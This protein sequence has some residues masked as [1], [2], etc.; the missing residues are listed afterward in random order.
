MGDILY[1]NII[2][3]EYIYSEYMNIY[4]YIYILMYILFLQDFKKSEELLQ[5]GKKENERLQLSKVAS[6]LTLPNFFSCVDG[7][8]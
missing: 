4:I 8:A 1:I 6:I 7:D 5:K 3:S 2:Y